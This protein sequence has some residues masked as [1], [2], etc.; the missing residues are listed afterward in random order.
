MCEH[1]ALGWHWQTAFEQLTAKNLDEEMLRWEMWH[2]LIRFYEMLLPPAGTLSRRDE[3]LVRGA[4]ALAYSRVG[5]AEQSRVYYMSALAIQRD[6]RDFL[7]EA[8]TLIN[9]GEFLRNTGELEQARSNFIEALNLVQPQ[10]QPEL[11]CIL[12]HNLALLTQ[13]MGDARQSLPY[14]LQAL[15]IAQFLQDAA[16]EGAILTNFGLFLCSQ[17]RYADGLALLFNAIQIRRAQQDPALDTLIAFLS[18]LEQRM[19][20]TMFAKLQQTAQ[21]SGK[22]VLQLLASGQ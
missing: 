20:R 21:V 12:A 1:L 18:K 4:L 22:Q 2:T 9:Q 13:Q 17:G 14:F 16:K 11:A 10:T 5:E 19:G 8:T 6:M 7:H 15:K 3:G